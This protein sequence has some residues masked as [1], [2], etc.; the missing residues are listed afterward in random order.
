[1]RRAGWKGT[2]YHRVLG[3]EPMVLRRIATYADT[4]LLFGSFMH[5]AGFFDK[6][7][8]LL[9]YSHVANQFSALGINCALRHFPQYNI[10]IW[11]EK[12]FPNNIFA[13]T[14]GWLLFGSSTLFSVSRMIMHLSQYLCQEKNRL[15]LSDASNTN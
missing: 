1:M 6:A 11:S 7:V 2:Q 8:C 3:P 15:P 14:A 5:G 10:Y 13:V 4:V 12:S 9:S